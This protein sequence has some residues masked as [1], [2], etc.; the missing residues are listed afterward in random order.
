VDSKGNF[1]KQYSR[2][3]AYAASRYTEV[4]LDEI[5]REIFRDIDKNVVD[6]ADNY[7]AT[8]LEP[9]LLPTT[10]PNLLVTP[11]QGI[12][13][14]MASTVCS[15]NLREVCHTTVQWLKNPQHNLHK[16]LP[17]PDFSTGG[18]LL[19]NQ[20]E[21][22]N[23]Y[24]AGRG[25]FK[26]RA[27]Y[28][29]D[30]KNGCIEIYEIPYTTTA[31]AVIDKVV[32][33]VKAGKL[34]DITDVR[35]ETDLHGLK[36]T[37]DIRKSAEPDMIMQRLYTLTTLQDTFS[38]NFNFLVDGKPRQMGI[39][40]I[41]TE[42]TR[43]R[44]GCIKRQLDTEIKNKKDKLHLLDGLSK[45]LLDID[46]AIRIIRQ[47]ETESQVIPN[48]MRGFKITEAQ[49]E[50]IAEIKLRNLNR[51]HLLNRV[52]E[53]DGLRADIEEMTDI[54]QSDE[55]IRS[56]ISQQLK[57]IAKKYGK[58]RRTQIVHAQDA[59]LPQEEVLV[60]DYNVKL[61]LTEHNYF[62]K[63]SLVS[64]RSSADQ[65][66][67]DDDAIIQELETANRAEVLFF[68]SQCAVYK[69]KVYD[70]PDCKASALGEY[71]TNILGMADGERAVYMAIANDYRGY[72]VFGFENGKVAKVGFDSY[73][74]KTNRKKLVNAYS[75]KSNI[76]A[77]YWIENDADF[78]LTRG[79]DKALLFNTSLIN[80]NTSKA[81]GGVQVFNL[82]RNTALTAI[83][84]ALEEDDYY[85]VDRIPSAGHFIR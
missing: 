71:L 63:I 36:I 51:E 30:R 12:A 79:K 59:P 45:I 19:Y 53:R 35:D 55:R 25:T 29:F 28:R 15:F 23:I 5:C 44:T 7:N 32:S 69:M 65:Y 20:A 22:E 82:R 33:L 41:L 49:A 46:K 66:L 78:Y 80:A 4:K 58:D 13:V 8:M 1:G 34:K 77:M 3:M 70:L 81:S 27:R 54:R 26:L 24:A 6:M 48:L 10:F 16:T 62:K 47:T 31:E 61:F 74:T 60:D 84:P 67:K 56:L 76:V 73:A 37:V 17:A 52:N 11:N 21:M 9:V 83:R 18:D 68:S 43:F 72:M 64:L 38:C 57:D 42:W 2:D 75:D 85:R 50:F 40:E 39:A 14:G